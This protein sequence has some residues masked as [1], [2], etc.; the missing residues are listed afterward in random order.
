MSAIVVHP[1]QDEDMKV[2]TEW[3]SRRKW[4]M[5]PMPHI[6]PKTGFVAKKGDKLCAVAWVYITNSSLAMVEWTATNPDET[7][8][9]MRGLKKIYEYVKEVSAPD[10]K[11]ILQFSSN[12]KLSQ[13]LE[14]RCG[15]KNSEKAD[16]MVWARSE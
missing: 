7:M 12:A 14:R 2:V 9:G 16:I 8:L 15:F 10:V 11:C 4:P 1:I 3:F 13:F 6:L 5:P